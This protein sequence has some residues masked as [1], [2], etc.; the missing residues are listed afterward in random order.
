MPKIF[1][2][3]IIIIHSKTQHGRLKDGATFMFVGFGCCK[4][5][6]PKEKNKKI[7]IGNFGNG[8][9]GPIYFLYQFYFDVNVIYYVNPNLKL[10]RQIFCRLF[11]FEKYHE[12]Q[13]VSGELLG[14]RW[15]LVET[16]K[17]T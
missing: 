10:A 6:N 1:P 8:G 14:K 11:N 13:L 2:H 3:F 9:F 12:Q 16:G 15:Y 5:S 4:S 7:K 17:Q